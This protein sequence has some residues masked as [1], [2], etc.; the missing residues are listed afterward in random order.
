MNNNKNGRTTPAPS[1]DVVVIGSGFG[2]GTVALRLAQAGKRVLVLERGRRW[3]GQ[4]MPPNAAPADAMPFP[5]MGDRHFFWGRQLFE[6]FKQRLGLF[7]VRQMVNL[8]GLLAAGV[9]GGSLIW[10]NVV[11]EAP[12]EVFADGWPQGLNRETLEP[13]YRKAEPYLR[14][15]FVPGTPGVPGRRSVR[16][17]QLMKDAAAKIGMPWRPVRVAV[18]FSDE[19]TARASAADAAAQM[20]CNFCG[21]CSAG[22]PQNAKN[23][24]DLTYIAAAEKLGAEIR[25]LHSVK[26]I[27]DTASGGYRIHFD[28][29]AGD[30]KL[31]EHGSID[32][33]QVVVSA[34]TFGTT[35]LL[36]R[37]RAQGHLKKLSDRL[38][39]KFSVNGNV[40]SG[41]LDPATPA[42][43]VEALGTNT[44]PAIASMI[45]CGSYVIEDFANPTWANGI[46][47]GT[48]IGRASA[49]IKALIGLKP[50]E[51]S[52][53]RKASDLLV[54]VG[55][56]RDRALG[57]LRLNRLGKL[58]LSWPG[59]INNEPVVRA[60]HATLE[61]L[62]RAQNRLYVPNVFSIFNRPLTYHPLG[63]C[64]M[65]DS[66]GEGVVDQYG[67]VFG[68]AGL[69]IAD[70]SI[71]PGA[72]GRNPSFT[73]AA[74]S[75][76]VAEQLL[77]ELSCKEE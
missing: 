48:S 23:T 49:F 14:P 62:A 52:L 6:P 69:R 37:S 31:I 77:H 12:P 25:T 45:D 73:I 60:L 74:L 35:E 1:F 43:K 19:Y 28:R 10:A 7:E 39:T 36:L 38:G 21:L 9:G 59:G 20:G 26:A 13:Y 17:A 42:A 68:H 58:S 3:R 61:R 24:V 57:K 72:I 46:V 70:G 30:G 27:E 53:V 75:E 55:V 33:A 66:A 41:A 50:S 56:G 44:G 63:G 40:L 4:N 18:N 51:K 71:V 76:R 65:A 29:F 34:G 32:C 8:Q 67:R 47:G 64:P 5:S 2:G 22:C 11:I 15:S 54:Y 16:R